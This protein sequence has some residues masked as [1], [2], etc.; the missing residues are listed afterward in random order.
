MNSADIKLEARDA[1]KGNWFK[2]IIASIVA[3]FFGASTVNSGAVS[4]SFNFGSGTQTTPEDGGDNVAVA[5]NMLSNSAEEGL[6][7][8]VIYILLLMGIISVMMFAYAIISFTIGSAV[9]VGYSHFNLNIVDGRG[10]AVGD[11][12][13]RF[14]QISTA[15]GIK[16]LTILRVTI[17]YILFVIPGIVATYSY[18]MANFVLA[19]NPGMT[20]SEAL[21]ESKRIMKGHRWELFCMQLSFIGWILLSVLTLGIAYIWVLPYYNAAHAAFYRRAKQ[22]A[23]FAY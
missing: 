8:L 5:F 13:S 20:A 12:F 7:P 10:A 15:I 3:S 21:K 18:A 23:D 9:S 17:G 22:A 4:F 16:L 2:A 19:E 6:S 11:L 1:L 14:S